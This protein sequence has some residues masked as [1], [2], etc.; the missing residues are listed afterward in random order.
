MP[1]DVKRREK[2]DNVALVWCPDCDIGTMRRQPTEAELT[3]SYT[4]PAYYTHGTTH[5]PK[6]TEGI[7][8]RILIKLA[9]LRDQ[10]Q[11]MTAERLLAHCA[12]SSAVVD[13]GCGNGDFLAALSGKGRRL[14]GVE[15]DPSACE[16]AASKGLT[17]L[18]GTAEQL[19]E[20]VA[21]E[22][23]DLVTLTHVL[24]H[25]RDPLRALRNVRGLLGP[26]G[27]FYCEVPNCGS[28]YFQTLAEIA[29]MLDVPRHLHFFT[30]ASL[31]GLC[32]KAGLEVFDWSYHGY[33]RHFGGAWRAWE[34][35]IHD[36]LT[37]T[38][39]EPA[40]PRRTWTNSYQLLARSAFVRPDRKYDCIGFFARAA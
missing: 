16:T 36:M 5:F 11:L 21:G 38:G 40:T 32:A 3:A 20:A 13:I 15:P 35:Q 34:N 24:E 33:T 25:C 22:R 10:G 6:V 17:V 39:A 9:Y 19:P 4:L 7:A 27:I 2:I 12:E 1:I 8:D 30:K 28:V 29:E 31:S 26:Q 23:F 18:E 37:G 14:T